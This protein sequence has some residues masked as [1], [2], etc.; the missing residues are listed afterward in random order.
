[1]AR[2]LTSALRSAGRVGFFP[3]LLGDP[4]QFFLELPERLAAFP[5]ETE[6][7]ARVFRG[8]RH[9]P[10]Q[11]GQ[12][13]KW[14]DRSQGRRGLSADE[15]SDSISPRPH[16]PLR[17]VPLRQSRRSGPA[18]AVNS[19]RSDSAASLA[20]SHSASFSLKCSSIG[21]AASRMVS[22]RFWWSVSLGRAPSARCIVKS[23][24]CSSSHF[25][26]LASSSDRA[27]ST[28]AVRCLLLTGIEY[29]RR[30]FNFDSVCSTVNRALRSSR[31]RTRFRRRIAILATDHTR[32]RSTPP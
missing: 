16:R 2:S 3:R 25:A 11:P 10:L 7:R 23:F 24:D 15:D 17:L 6:R 20:F 27:F 12:R 26:F 21:M 5:D 19:S 22:M 32:T 14:L 1:M 28:S 30:T 29:S 18:R 13:A 8:D 4:Q 31:L 9:A